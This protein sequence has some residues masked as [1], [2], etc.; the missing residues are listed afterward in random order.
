MQLTSHAV[1]QAQRRG[2]NADLIDCIFQYGE[3]YKA[4]GGCSL[5]RISAKE[6]RF[7]KSENPQDWKSRRDHHQVALVLN[8][9]V[10]IT[11]MHRVKPLKKSNRLI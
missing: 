7:L 11:V 2:I 5:Y 1:K 6:Q 10:I 8:R 9:D 4:G 3:E